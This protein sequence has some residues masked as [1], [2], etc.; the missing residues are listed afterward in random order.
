VSQAS[1]EEA[2]YNISGVL[3]DDVINEK[4]EMTYSDQHSYTEQAQ[5]RETYF[6][7]E[8][9]TKIDKAILLG[10][11]KAKVKKNN[12][13]DKSAVFEGIQSALTLVLADEALGLDAVQNHIMARNIVAIVEKIYD[14]SDEGALNTGT[15]PE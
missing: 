15:A 12:S 13:Y 9:A 10:L 4:D 2:S 5:G 8:L 3:E 1:L 14:H 11:L 6:F 7:H